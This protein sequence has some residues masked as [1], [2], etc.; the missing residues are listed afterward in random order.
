VE[1]KTA[2]D[3]ALV[4][5]THRATQD[6][7]TVMDDDDDD[8]V[9][10]NKEQIDEYAIPLL[11]RRAARKKKRQV[12]ITK[13]ADKM[14][15]DVETDEKKEEDDEYAIPHLHRRTARKKRSQAVIAKGVD[16]I[17]GAV[18]TDDNA[19]PQRRRKARAA[20]GRQGGS[21]YAHNRPPQNQGVGSQYFDPNP[22]PQ[23]TYD[24]NPSG[25][26]DPNGNPGPYQDLFLPDDDSPYYN[27]P[28]PDPHARKPQWRNAAPRKNPGPPTRNDNL[29]N[30]RYTQFDFDSPQ[31]NKPNYNP[32]PNS[33]QG[34]DPYHKGNPN[35][36]ANSP[37]YNP[38]EMYNPKQVDRQLNVVK[39]QAKRRGPKLPELYDKGECVCEGGD[40]R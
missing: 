7:G 20:Q 18:E 40:G 6:S 16:N 8:A 28:N 34:H 21:R 30:P 27:P 38:S 13:S 35:A 26:Y 3:S 11:H 31:Q 9:D 32:N 5:K 23:N 33:Q 37:K 15:G 10:K 14:E 22:R 39:E 2:G 24:P 17:E 1:R 36:N 25:M 19:M 29:D 12:V 4:Q